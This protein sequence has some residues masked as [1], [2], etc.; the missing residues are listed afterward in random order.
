MNNEWIN[1]NDK[2]PELGPSSYDAKMSKKVLVKCDRR[3][4]F[5]AHIFADSGKYKTYAYGFDEMGCRYTWLNPY[6]DI[7]ALQRITHWMPLDLVEP[8]D[9]FV[10]GNLRGVKHYARNIDM[11]FKII[12]TPHP[13]DFSVVEWAMFG[14]MAVHNMT[15][16]EVKE[17]FGD[18]MLS[19]FDLL[20]T[21]G[22]DEYHSMYEKLGCSKS[23]KLF[24]CPHCKTEHRI[25]YT[26]FR[27]YPDYLDEMYYG[28]C[29][30]GRE[31]TLAKWRD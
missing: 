6:Q 5:I 31:F 8:Q 16:V 24:V 4:P 2:L 29:S 28:N 1:V 30:C 15:W 27:K 25:G 13:D 26:K 12:Q 7:E 23:Y 22:W 14:Q 9:D 11:F 3:Y 17:L 18:D 20:E 19:V 21:Y 10:D